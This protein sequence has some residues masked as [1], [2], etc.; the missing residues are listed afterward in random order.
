MKNIL[1]VDPNHTLSIESM[2]ILEE[3]NIKLNLEH[4]FRKLKNKIVSIYLFL[5][6]CIF[7]I[8]FLIES[9]IK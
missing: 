2:T 3:Y 7:S 4:D 1:I 8:C 9:I 5:R 6:F